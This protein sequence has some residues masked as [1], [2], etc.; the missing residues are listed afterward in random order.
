MGATLMT[1]PRAVQPGQIKLAAHL[2][3]QRV[4][5]HFCV[6]RE[7]GEPLVEV[8]ADLFSSRNDLRGQ[9]EVVST[10]LG[11]GHI[12]QSEGRLDVGLYKLD[13]DARTQGVSNRMRHTQGL[14]FALKVHSLAPSFTRLSGVWRGQSGVPAGVFSFPTLGVY[15]CIHRDRTLDVCPYSP[16][17][18]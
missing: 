1:W 7:P 15:G 8:A 13:L 11:F 14:P 17:S 10:R 2:A 16:L 5:R 6:F 18:V 12:D 9:R 3:D 4:K